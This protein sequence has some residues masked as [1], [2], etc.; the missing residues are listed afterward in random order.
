MNRLPTVAVGTVS[1]LI[2][3]L[4]LVFIVTNT[5]PQFD[6]VIFN[7]HVEGGTSDKLTAFAVGTLSG[8]V[9]VI[10]AIRLR[11]QK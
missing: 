2:A 8:A 11:K 10:C 4:C 6:T 5:G 7:D 3:M 9:G 1:F